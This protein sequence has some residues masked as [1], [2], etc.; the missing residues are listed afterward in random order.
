VSKPTGVRYAEI[1]HENS[2]GRVRFVLDID[3][4]RKSTV[5]TGIGYLD[6]M[7]GLLAYA[8]R[9]DIGITAEGD[10]LVHDV[11]TVENVGICFGRALAHALGDD[12][13]ILKF[14]SE[15]IPQDDSLVL[16]ALELFGRP[17]LAFDAPFTTDRI[18]GLSADSV[19]L[20]L[21]AFAQ[22]AGLT[23]HIKKLAGSNNHLTCMAIFK[24]LGAALRKAVTPTET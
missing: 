8:G 22:H 13:Q 18:G 2:H 17:Y 10:L 24:G 23:L 5:D 16:V 19:E 6:S 14:A 15:L 12:K 7:I 21:R 3:G 9:F 1:E 20:F 4:E 11:H